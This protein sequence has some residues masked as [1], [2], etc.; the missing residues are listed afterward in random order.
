MSKINLGIDSVIQDSFEIMNFKKVYD[1]D[2]GNVSSIYNQ[3]VLIQKGKGTLYTLDSVQQVAEHQIILLP[4]NQIYRF[5]E[6]T[7]ISGLR[8]LFGDCIWDR[9]PK[10]VNDCKL[11]LFEG[12]PFRA[13]QLN[14]E[15]YQ[16]LYSIFQELLAEYKSQNYINKIDVLAA[17]LKI[18]LIKL[19]NTFQVLENSYDDYDR[20]LYQD[21]LKLMDQ[22]LLE[23]LNVAEYADLLNISSKKLLNICKAI[24]KTS[25][26]NILDNKL[27]A[28]AKNLL[29]FSVVP[30]KEVAFR[31]GFNSIYQFSKFF[32]NHT[33]VAPKEYRLLMEEIDKQ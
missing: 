25:P 32:K 20:Q 1:K 3:I 5:S 24:S 9:A 17:Y 26:K 22:K 27:V 12:I 18:V 7:K 2:N 11:M 33:S 13:L 15:F 6:E 28:E 23:R 16:S 29:I 8:L 14:N 21:F 30:I 4:K 31:L 10:S 19:A